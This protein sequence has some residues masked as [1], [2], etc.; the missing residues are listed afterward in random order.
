MLKQSVCVVCVL[1]LYVLVVMVLFANDHAISMVLRLLRALTYFQLYEEERGR[2]KS[3]AQCCVS[4]GNGLATRKTVLSLYVCGTILVIPHGRLAVALYRR[5][6]SEPKSEVRVRTF[7]KHTSWYIVR[8]RSS[9]ILDHA[10]R[11]RFGLE[12]KYHTQL[13]KKKID[14]ERF[15]K[16][17][18][19][20]SYLSRL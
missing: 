19:M 11:L 2:S 4:G 12:S 15:L 18:K 8:Y 13:P 10:W 20:L 7:A 17:Q 9:T 14:T 6:R 1:C 5:A 3:N 16:N